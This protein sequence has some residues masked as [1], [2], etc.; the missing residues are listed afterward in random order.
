M[1]QPADERYDHVSRPRSDTYMKPSLSTSALH[2]TAEEVRAAVLKD[3]GKNTRTCSAF[4]FT[5]KVLPRLSVPGTTGTPPNWDDTLDELIKHGWYDDGP[6]PFWKDMPKRAGGNESKYYAPVANIANAIIYYTSK[7]IP[8]VPLRPYWIDR[9]TRVPVSTQAQHNADIRPD[10]NCFLVSHDDNPELN[11]EAQIFGFGPNWILMMVFVI[12]I[13]TAIGE[14][15]DDAPGVAHDSPPEGAQEGRSTNRLSQ[16]EEDEESYKFADVGLEPEEE[17]VSDD[18]LD[19]DQQTLLGKRPRDDDQIPVPQTEQLERVVAYWMRTLAIMEIKS[20][21]GQGKDLDAAIIVQVA[22]YMRQMLREQH[23]R[24]FVFGLVLCHDELYLWYCDRSGLL[25][26]VRPIEINKKPKAFIQVIASLALADPTQLGW[27]PTMKLGLLD[28]LNPESTYLPTRYEFSWEP[29][30]KSSE[31]PRHPGKVHWS[32]DVDGV[33]YTTIEALSVSR[34]EVMSGRASIVWLAIPQGEPKSEPV[35]I[36]QGWPPVTAISEAGLYEKTKHSPFLPQGK[37][38]H[39]ST[40]LGP[41]GKGKTGAEQLF[42][43]DVPGIPEM[44][45]TLFEFIPREQRRIVLDTYGWP[46]KYFKDLE[47]LLR[48]LLCALQG[49]ESLYNEGICHRDVSATN[50]IIEGRKVAGLLIDLDH[51]K[52]DEVPCQTLQE[53]LED[54]EKKDLYEAL[55]AKL[56]Q[57]VHGDEALRNIDE[58]LSRL[59]IL[60]YHIRMGTDKPLPHPAKIFGD[61][62]ALIEIYSNDSERSEDLSMSDF[63]LHPEMLFP[64]GFLGRMVSK[65]FRTGTLAFT[66]HRLLGDQGLDIHSAIHDMESFFW[67]L[68]WICLTRAGPG[69]A[70][71]SP[72]DAETAAEKDRFERVAAM[73]YFF[74]D[75]PQSTLLINKQAL[76]SNGEGDITKHFFPLFSPYFEPL[77]ELILEWFR[78][79]DLAFSPHHNSAIVYLFPI[80]LFRA[81]LEKAIKKV[82]VLPVTEETKLVVKRRQQYLDKIANIVPEAPSTPVKALSIMTLDPSPIRAGSADPL[83][84]LRDETYTSRTKDLDRPFKRPAQ[85]PRQG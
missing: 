54:N 26:T 45:Y 34:A 81:A 32:I 53:V 10:L 71:S 70:Q 67:V 19:V 33:F 5:R 79:L 68:I 59:F 2:H 27:D 61:N 48:A 41:K 50:V 11:F 56:M 30:L 17:D 65:G 13:E 42:E 84:N 64:P 15:L 22:S 55:A 3:I 74:F 49:Y 4:D 37:P 58:S 44:R 39:L 31:L 83:D 29:K 63:G 82:S 28:A 18:E 78:L 16:V 6:R 35:V 51:A 25:G 38:L 52:E 77:Q 72:S 73:R 40:M 21:T 60:C 47:E 12:I 9:A 76:F 75:G 66:S 43:N 20:S 80:G 46:L 7:Q 57:S 69:V 85:A 14:A 62:R 8:D 36:K 24:R 23:D 1:Y